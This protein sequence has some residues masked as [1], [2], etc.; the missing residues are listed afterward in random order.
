MQFIPTQRWLVFTAA[1]PAVTM[2]VLV[3]L[4]ACSTSQLISSSNPN[5]SASSSPS[6]QESVRGTAD[7]S[8]PLTAKLDAADNPW[9]TALTDGAIDLPSWTLEPCEGM[10]AFLCVYDAAG[11]LVGTVELQSWQLQERTDW[12]HHLAEAGLEPSHFNHQ[13]S[14]QQKQLH[15]ALTLWVEDFYATVQQDW[16]SAYGEAIAFKSQAPVALNLGNYAG[17]AYGFSGTQNDGTIQQHTIGYVTF[18]GEWLHIVTTAA[19][20]QEAPGFMTV[21]QLQIFQPDF[22]QIIRNLKL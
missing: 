2:L 17:L 7:Q 1:R 8:V 19:P 5:S 16:A 11:D 3:S 12:A 4:T 20:N 22:T 10:A 18:D 21:E 13:D 15:A 6:T 14:A 9:K